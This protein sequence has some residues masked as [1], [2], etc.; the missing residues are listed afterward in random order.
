MWII[1]QAESG[2]WLVHDDAEVLV[3]SGATQEEAWNFLVRHVADGYEALTAA[4]PAGALPERWTSGPSGICLSAETGDGRDFTDCQWTWRDVPLPL[5]LQTETEFGHM[6]A[7]LAGWFD[8]IGAGPGGGVAA[9]GWFHDSEEGRKAR[10]ILQAQGQFGISVD[11]GAVTA[12]FVCTAYEDD[13]WCMDGI[14]KFLAYEVIGGTMTPFPAFALAWLILDPAAAETTDPGEPLPPAVAEDAGQTAA[15]EPAVAAAAT[16]TATKT[17]RLPQMAWFTDEEP[18]DGDPRYVDQRDE[19]IAVPLTIT[20]DRRVFGHVAAWGTCHIGYV[21]Q[22]VTPPASASGYAHFHVGEVLTNEGRVATGA[23][24]VGTDHAA[25]TL[26][27]AEARDHYAHTGLAWADVRAS[28]GHHGVWVAG[29][30]REDVTDEALEVIRASAPS[31]DWRRIGGSLEMISC[32]QVSV[33][34]FPIV[35]EAI[36]AAG[37]DLADG[38]LQSRTEGGLQMAL[39]AAGIVLPA[40]STLDGLLASGTIEKCANCGQMHR[41]TAARP[42]PSLRE[43]LARLERIEAAQGTLLARTRPLNALR[44]EALVRQLRDDS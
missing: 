1:K 17:R 24:T 23:M 8:T 7:E 2:A 29:R 6:G 25:L 37:I 39:V 44:R 4:A 35:R 31:G 36:T 18:E 38:A 14:T 40:G 33:P 13:G 16:K 10:D 26:L 5:M 12:E 30:V 9:S 15:D 34:G 11:P 32:L 27:A 41:R 42:E 19:R 3:A 43:V 20:D 21:N 28:D 22:C